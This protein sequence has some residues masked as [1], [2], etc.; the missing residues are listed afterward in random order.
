MACKCEPTPTNPHPEVACTT[1]DPCEVCGGDVDL[2]DCGSGCAACG[3]RGYTQHAER[4]DGMPAWIA[5]A[6]FEVAARRANP[7]GAA[8]EKRM[9]A[10]GFDD[11]EAW[12]DAV[13]KHA[14]YLGA[15]AVDE[16]RL[17]DE[18]CLR[19]TLWAN[20]GPRLSPA[21]LDAFVADH[22]LAWATEVLVAL[23]DWPPLGPWGTRAEWA[24]RVFGA[25]VGAAAMTLARAV[26]EARAKDAT[27]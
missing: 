15:A 10:L 5:S 8:V 27:A 26:E 14:S 13:A 16:L 11:V 24:E 6:R 12:R 23:G 9:R 25:D 22:G 7:A 2:G 4:V 17:L 21:V 3:S 1:P 19:A 18:A 20:P